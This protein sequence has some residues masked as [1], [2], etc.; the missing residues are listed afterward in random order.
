MSWG[1]SSWHGVG[2]WS[3]DSWSSDSWSSG[4]GTWGHSSYGPWRGE[5]DWSHHGSWRNDDDGRWSEPDRK[6]PPKAANEEDISKY[7]YLGGDA[8]LIL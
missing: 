8:H 6:P 5:A 7:S 3:G 1:A 2:N 4:W